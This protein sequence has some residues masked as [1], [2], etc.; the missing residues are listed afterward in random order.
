MKIIFFGSDD[1]AAVS[2]SRL[3]TDGHEIAAVVT[4]PDKAQG[5]GMNV[6]LLP[7]KMIALERMISVFQPEDLNDQDF[8]RALRSFDADLFVVIA[9]GKFLP[10]EILEMPKIFSMNVHA[11][12]LPKYRGA[13]PINQAIIDGEERTGVTVIKMNERMDAGDIIAQDGVNIADDVDSQTLRDQ[14]AEAG[15]NCLSRTVQSLAGG[16]ITLIPQDEKEATFAYKLTREMGAIDWNRP[17][18]DIHNLV[19]GLVPWPGAYTCFQGKRL[20]VLKTAVFCQEAV[21]APPGSVVKLIPE[22]IAVACKGGSLL[23]K[24]VQLESSKVMD[25]RS[26]SIGHQVRIGTVFG[27]EK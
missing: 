7:V 27:G 26:F 14:L 4:P 25:A 17:A 5:R 13:A 1:F 18:R 23:L 9:Y 19:R 20:K 2:L 21:D 8:Q 16:E 3:I 6:M 11:S 10:K 12:L 24:D 15:A 22:G